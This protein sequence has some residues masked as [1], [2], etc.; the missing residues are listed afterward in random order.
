MIDSIFKAVWSIIMM[1]VVIGGLFASVVVAA[2]ISLLADIPFL[3]AYAIIFAA[4][5]I[6]TGIVRRML[7]LQIQSQEENEED[8]KLSN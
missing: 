8:N 3:L 6:I 5:W 1:F 7:I 2:L 4:G